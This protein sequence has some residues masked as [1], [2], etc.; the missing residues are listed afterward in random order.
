MKRWVGASLFALAAL[1]A[2]AVAVSMLQRPIGLAMTKRLAEANVGRDATRD[3]PDGLHA[4]LCGSGSPLPDPARAGPCTVVVAGD[5]VF[6]VDA[7]EGGPRNL[8][9]M[10]VPAG[11]IEA[12]FLTHFHSDHID[13]LGGLMLQRWAGGA[14]QD[15]TPVYGPEGV[16]RVVAGFNAAYAM[17]FG[18]RVAHHGPAITPPT[19][20]GGVAR[21]FVL[22]PAGQGDATVVLDDG[23]LKV[24][25]F[26]VMHDPVSPAVGYRFDYKGRSLVIS[27]D[28]ARSPVL[29]RQ[30]KGADLIL[31]E[32]LQ[33]EM[34]DV[35]T[36]A[37]KAKGIDNLATV[38][39]DIHD[40]HATPEQAAESAQV[41]GADML[42]LTHVVPPVPVRYLEAAFVGDARRRF[43]GKIV[44]G[45]DGMLFSLPAGGDAVRRS[46][47]F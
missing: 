16:D 18:Y 26:R 1:V 19:G 32:A 17:D 6:V 43:D 7:G 4:A 14:R 41:A 8:G 38:T 46:R 35:L 31:H 40:Y 21:P 30:A 2:A 47:M 5:R 25:A 45:R 15:P 28:T 20:A 11:R 24:T 12:V 42:V 34:L 3:L 44:V 9:R 22:P 13:A 10:G 36:A 27:G 33:P 29:E 37:L 23:G 39:T